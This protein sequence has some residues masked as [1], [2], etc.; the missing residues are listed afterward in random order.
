MEK[1]DFSLARGA[2]PSL[3]HNK[4]PKPGE[5]VDFRETEL[6]RERRICPGIIVWLPPR[7][8]GTQVVLLVGRWTTALATMLTSTDGLHTIEQ[9]L[10]KIGSPTGWEMVVQ[11]EVQADTTVLRTWPVAVHPV[12]ASYWK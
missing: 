6:S 3:V 11:A 4:A 5:P 8:E 12:S 9:E 1:T 2:S 10:K 7:P